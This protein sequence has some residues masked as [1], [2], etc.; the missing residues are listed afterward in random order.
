MHSYH[1]VRYGSDSRTAPRRYHREKAEILESSRKSE[2]S[3][4]NTIESISSESTTDAFTCST[5]NNKLYQTNTIVRD[6]TDDIFSFK[7]MITTLT[8]II[9]ISGNHPKEPTFYQA[10]SKHIITLSWEP[11]MGTVMSAK[12]NS[13]I[14]SHNIKWLPKYPIELPIIIY[15][16][17]IRYNCT[18]LV[19]PSESN[20]IQ[21]LFQTGLNPR[22]NDTIRIPGGCVHWIKHD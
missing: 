10:R 4:E 8:N 5:D 6:A 19:S 20:Y 2:T 21:F 13:I 18:V 11:F 7:P 12:T 14:I 22:I 3:S 15:L 16:Q 1:G 9:V 17:N